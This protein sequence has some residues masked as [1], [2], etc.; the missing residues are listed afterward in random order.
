MTASVNDRDVLSAM[1][2]EPR[3]GIWT[4]E[5]DADNETALTG[6]ITLTIDDVAWH[7]TVLRG[8]VEAGHYHAWVVG[9][10][11][12]LAKQV[13]AKHYLSAAGRLIL[14]E[15]LEAC[16]ETLAATTDAAVLTKV[17]P[18]WSRAKGTAG[19]ALAQFA[20][21]SGVSWRVLRDGTVWLGLETWPE[22]K[23]TYDELEYMPARGAI[24][25]APEQPTV[26]PGEHFDGGNIA[27]VT[28][29]VGPDGTRQTILYEDATVG[30]QDRP[31]QQLENTIESVVGRRLNLSNWY[32]ARVVSQATD[33]S[34][35]LLPDDDRMRGAGISRVPLRHGLPGCTVKVKPGARVTL[36]FENNDAKQPAAGLWP[37]GSSVLQIEISAD[38]MVKLTAPTVQVTG[39]LVVTGSIN[40]AAISGDA[41]SAG[42]IGLTTHK[43]TETGGTTTTPIP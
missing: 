38:L 25:I 39:N 15:L 2:R 35:D 3:I 8:D 32:A 43:H 29:N 5:L 33:G 19:S 9:G 24:D 26:K 31:R 20:A 21:D 41:V 4:C 36:F 40:A 7:G 28:T 30:A 23:V 18:R 10:K 27:L 6:D 14:R 1:V 12:G 11:Y 22:S 13:S 17:F 34:V 42:G 16:G 37:D